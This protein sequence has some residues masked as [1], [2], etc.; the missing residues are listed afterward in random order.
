MSQITKLTCTLSALAILA[1]CGGGANRSTSLPALSI[2]TTS[3]PD[4]MV[5]FNYAQSIQA[6]GGI[7]PFA[8]NVSSGRLPNNVS[9]GIGSTNTANISGI[10]DTAQTVTFTIQVRDVKDQMAVQTYTLN[11]NSTGIAQLLPIAGQ[12]PGG[13][14]EIQGVSAGPF[15]PLSW[16]LDTLN[17]VPDVRM[18]MFAAQST[19]P[20]QNIYAPWPLE[21]AN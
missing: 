5:A 18:P 16:Q 10:P 1:S 14:I 12:V 8:W 3:L 6:T 7:A 17:W 15:N 19:G 2:F 13:T 4:G 9:L 11:I 20:Y 21:Q